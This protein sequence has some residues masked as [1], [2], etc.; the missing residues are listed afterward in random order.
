MVRGL[1]VRPL[2]DDTALVNLHLASGLPGAEALDVAACLR[3]LDNWAAQVGA[4]TGRLSY[5]FRRDPSRFEGSEARFQMMVM[6]TVLQRDLGVRYR[7]ELT[8]LP[9]GEFFGRSEHLFI[10]GVINGSGGTCLSLPATYVAVAQ[11][12]GYPLKLVRTARH[13]FARWDCTSGERFNVESTCQ[14]FVTYPDEHYRH[15]PV[16]LSPEA[17]RGMGALLSLTPIQEAALFTQTRGQCFDANGRLPEAVGAYAR[18]ADMN[19][20]D[21]LGVNVLIDAM[22]RW[23]TD[24]YLKMCRGFPPLRIHPPRRRCY[25]SLPLQTE[26]ALAHLR[27]KQM[28]LTDLEFNGKWWTPLKLFPDLRPRGLPAFITVRL[29]ESG[30]GEAEIEFHDTVPSDFDRATAKPC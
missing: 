21:A 4:E 17:E 18:A 9:D 15:W 26:L 28:L 13:C 23:D 2:R 27:T 8:E 19:P 3:T 1:A 22:R 11:R 5:V 14:G 25:P 29:P 20:T 30:D 6:I 16:E 7:Q 12:L 24:L 10:H